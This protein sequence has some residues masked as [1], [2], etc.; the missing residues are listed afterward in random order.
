MRITIEQLQQ[1]PLFS[2]LDFDHLVQLQTHATV[3]PYSRGEIILHEGDRLPAK[4][5]F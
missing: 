4:R 5:M 1:L 3:K 2:G